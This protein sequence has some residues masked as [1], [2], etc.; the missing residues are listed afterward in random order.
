[1]QR[2][3]RPL[4]AKKRSRMRRLGTRGRAK[5]EIQSIL[6]KCHAGANSSRARQPSALVTSEIEQSDSH[7]AILLDISPMGKCVSRSLTIRRFE[8]AGV[9]RW[10]Q[11]MSAGTFLIGV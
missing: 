11:W 9:R 7:V 10:C 8:R 2:G 6:D 1:M 5:T 3:F 4:L